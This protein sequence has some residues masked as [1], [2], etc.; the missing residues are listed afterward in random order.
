MKQIKKILGK[1]VSCKVHNLIPPK[2]TP[3]IFEEVGRALGPSLL[4]LTNSNP[5]SRI[6]NSEFRSLQGLRNSLKNEISRGLS[7]ARVSKVSVERIF[8]NSNHSKMLQKIFKNITESIWKIFIKCLMFSLHDLLIH[9]LFNLNSFFSSQRRRARNGRQLWH[10]P[11]PFLRFKIC[12][13]RTKP[14]HY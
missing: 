6:I 9:S 14:V 10:C 2:F 3:S 4:D 1:E 11:L 5:C 13:R 12:W 8:Q 7:K